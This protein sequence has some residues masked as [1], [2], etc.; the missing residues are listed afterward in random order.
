VLGLGRDTVAGRLRGHRL[1]ERLL[2]ALEAWI[3]I[4]PV[5]AERKR[6][7]L[8]EVLRAADP[9]AGSF[10]NRRRGAPAREGKG[11]VGALAGEAEVGTLPA[12][13]LSLLG[14]ALRKVGAAEATVRLLQEG[15]ARYRGDF[16][17]N[18][19]LAITFGSMK[20][21]RWDEA[22]RFYSVAVALRSQSAPAHYNLGNAL[23]AKTHVKAAI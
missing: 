8:A 7:A 21:P 13:V 6:L 15:Q 20:P 2:A 10:R 11:K 23:K 14:R 3:A 4:T 22:I 1:R 5:E 12:D 19:E 17:L 9:D 16:W 18:F